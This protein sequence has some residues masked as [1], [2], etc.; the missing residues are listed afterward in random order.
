MTK[1]ELLM[2]VANVET[3]KAQNI[4]G[5]SEN[6]YNCYYA[7]K[8]TFTYEELEKMSEQELN[9]LIKLANNIAEGLY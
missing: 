3:T 8:H 5:C 4:M 2:N 1:D 9:N 7:I 6:W